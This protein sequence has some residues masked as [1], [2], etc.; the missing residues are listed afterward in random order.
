MPPIMWH[1][2]LVAGCK[3]PPA[4]AVS[5]DTAS[6]SFVLA[7]TNDL[8]ARFLPSRAKWIDGQPDIGGFVAID[9]HVRSLRQARGDDNVLLLDGGDLLTGT[10]LMDFEVRGAMGGAMHEFLEAVGYDAAVVGNHEFDLGWEN[11]T[12]FVEAAETTTMLSANLDGP[13]GTPLWPT[14]KDHEIYEVGGV[15][16]G[17]FGVTTDDLHTLASPRVMDRVTLLGEVE[18]ARQQVEILESQVDLVVALTHIGIDRDKALAEAVPGIDLI[19][20]GH[21]HTP[22]YEPVTVGQTR[23][24]QAGCYARNLGVLELSVA[25]GEIETARYELID[26]LPEQV[27]GPAGDE[28]TALTERYQTAIDERFA[29]V[30]GEVTADL[31]RDYHAESPL[32][33]WASDMVRL[34]TESDVG[35]YN[36][37]GLR[38]D[39]FAGELTRGGLYQV[40]PFANQVVT[41]TVSGEELQAMLVHNARSEAAGEGGVLQLSG[42]QMRWMPEDDGVVVESLAVGGGPLD[43]TQRYKVATNSYVAEQWE[44][45]LSIE[46]ADLESLGRTVFTVA[47]AHVQGGPVADPADP[48]SIRLDP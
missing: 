32:G 17:V 36:A 38:S 25:G 4:S 5:S 18:A 47:E 9:G 27:P 39:L 1:L 3:Q 31:G 35:L 44:K 21:S 43:P 41:F 33:R 28:V 26:L 37:G 14:L 34:A 46:P 7:H 8:H 42:V 6:G 45:Y 29:E 15:R 10:P 2:L 24:V 16:V 20:G 22:L 12:A 48:R 19:V 13:D 23:I 30:I 40:F 11:V